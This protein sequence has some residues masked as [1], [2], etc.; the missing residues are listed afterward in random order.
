MQHKC[1]EEKLEKEFKEWARQR[2][3]T[4]CFELQT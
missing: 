3:V 1:K 4:I 2:T